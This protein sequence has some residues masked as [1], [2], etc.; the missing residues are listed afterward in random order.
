MGALFQSNYGSIIGIYGKK[1]EKTVKKLLKQDFIQFLGSD[2]HRPNQIYHNIPKIMKKL[3]RIISIEKI[4]EL[5]TINP[6]KV[7]DNEEI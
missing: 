1:A 6:Q 4:E 3:K 7:L 2:V 5:T